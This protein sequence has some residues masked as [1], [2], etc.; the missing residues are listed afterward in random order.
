MTPL[1][2]MQEWQVD[3]CQLHDPAWAGLTEMCETDLE[4]DV[5]DDQ[6]ARV[7]EQTRTDD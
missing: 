3:E 4:M 7:Q 1:Y 5:I 2:W 6:E